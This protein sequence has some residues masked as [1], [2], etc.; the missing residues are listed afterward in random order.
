M[1]LELLTNAAVIDDAARFVS[2]YQQQEHNSKN[3]SATHMSQLIEQEGSATPTT[4]T[5]QVF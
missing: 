4:T 3:A 5:N 1:K 2:H